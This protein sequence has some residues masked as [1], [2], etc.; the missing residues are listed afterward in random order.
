MLER[1][2]IKFSL[3]FLNFEGPLD[4]LLHLVR[5]NKLDINDIPISEVTRQYLEYLEIMRALNIE[6]ASE[7]LVMAATL[8]YIKSRSLL[9]RHEEVEE[10]E[11]P[12]EMR[13]EMSRRLKE[14]EKFREASRALSEKP[15]L[16]RDVF[17]R[18]EDSERK[19][20]KGTD[21]PLTEASLL[22]LISAFRE[23]MDRVGGGEIHAVTVDRLSIAD[24]MGFLIDRLESERVIRFSDVMEEVRTRA[25]A[26]AFFLAILELAFMGRISLHQEEPFG[27]ITI[28]SREERV[29]EE[30]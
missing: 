1:D 9:P 26:I 27:D 21:V 18:E 3:P 25:E 17:V 28:I 24:A 15:I 19:E 7:F 23:V 8:L 10:E 6:I 14:Y 20:I 12:E 13:R 29:Q 4:L 16:G 30:S 22:D 2:E 5:K 11:D